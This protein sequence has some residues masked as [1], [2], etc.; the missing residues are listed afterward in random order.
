MDEPVAG[1]PASK[2][3]PSRPVK[4]P[5]CGRRKGAL[6]AYGLPS[7]EDWDEIKKRM[8]AGAMVLGGCCVTGEDPEYK[9]AACDHKWG[10][11]K[12]D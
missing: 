9:C 7:P 10:L 6:I 3:L 5:A 11:A 1:E 2:E 4:C 8:D 12:L